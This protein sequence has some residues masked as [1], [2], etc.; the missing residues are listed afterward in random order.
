MV[1][2]QSTP[3]R[4]SRRRWRSD[5]PG[6]G[7]INSRSRCGQ[8]GQIF[9]VRCRHESPRAKALGPWRLIEVQSEFLCE[10]YRVVGNDLVVRTAYSIQY[11]GCSPEYDIPVDLVEVVEEGEV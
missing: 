8:N 2:D 9:A 7:R 4:K 5:K 3:G 6:C 10:R 11:T 1:E